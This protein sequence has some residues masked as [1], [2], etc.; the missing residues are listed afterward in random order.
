RKTLK[1]K[2]KANNLTEDSSTEEDPR[3]TKW[4]E[5]DSIIMAWLWNSMILEITDTWMFVNFAKEIWNAME[6]T[7]SKAKDAAQIYDVKVKTVTAK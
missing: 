1:G 2:G 5:E 7:Y 6:Q 3:F 4:D